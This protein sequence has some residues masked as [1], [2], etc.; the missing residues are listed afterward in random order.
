MPYDSPSLAVTITL[1]G[2][3]TVGPRRAI[4]I[5]V[6]PGGGGNKDLYV[7]VSH[8]DSPEF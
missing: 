3:R 1:C 6:T 7:K 4:R 8:G 2:D 5:V